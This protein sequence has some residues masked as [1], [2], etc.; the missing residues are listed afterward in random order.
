MSKAIIEMP[1]SCAD[2]PCNDDEYSV[3]RLDK[4]YMSN[5]R[6]VFNREKP[7]WCPLQI[8]SKY[9]PKETEIDWRKEFE[10]MVRYIGAVDYGKE[11]WFKETEKSGRVRWYDRYDGEYLTTDELQQ[12]IYEIVRKLDE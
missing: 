11:R 9:Y 6:F 8:A 1:N 7:K 5:A 10:D 2:C 12:R 4:N 3:C